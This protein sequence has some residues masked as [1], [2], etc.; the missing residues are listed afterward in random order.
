MRTFRL[1]FLVSACLPLLAVHAAPPTTAPPENP[2][3]ASIAD[4]VYLQEVASKV[5]TDQP[6]TAVATLDDQ[7]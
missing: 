2:L 7:V 5:V 3:Y 6:V 1:L 4:E